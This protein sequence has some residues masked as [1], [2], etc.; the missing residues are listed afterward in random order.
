MRAQDEVWRRTKDALSRLGEVTIA[1]PREVLE[2]LEEAPKK[3]L[4]AGAVIGG[5]RA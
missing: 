4:P 1:V 5:V 2:K 3:A